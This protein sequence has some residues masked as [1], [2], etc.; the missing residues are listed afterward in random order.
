MQTTVLRIPFSFYKIV[1]VLDLHVCDHAVKE[2]SILLEKK[3]QLFET[4]CFFPFRGTNWPS[5]IHIHITASSVV[6][7]DPNSSFPVPSTEPVF[8][9]GV[10]L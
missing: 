2:D 5:W 6:D 10:L 8:I 7:T 9:S 1:V 3:N 4:N